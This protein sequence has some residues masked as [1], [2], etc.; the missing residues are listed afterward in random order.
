MPTHQYIVVVSSELV[1]CLPDLLMKVSNI[2]VNHI[3]KLNKCLI[4]WLPLQLI[5]ISQ[6][7]PRVHIDG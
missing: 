3:N 1:K 6:I 2:H 4:V 7:Q 5:Y